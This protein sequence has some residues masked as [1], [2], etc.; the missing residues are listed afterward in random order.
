MTSASGNALG[1]SAVLADALGAAEALEV[2][3]GADAEVAG[4]DWS[5]S[6]HPARASAIARIRF[7][8]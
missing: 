4:V 5:G 8:E 3:V 2:G 1:S 7:I 6:P